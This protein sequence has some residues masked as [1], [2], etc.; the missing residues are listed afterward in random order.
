[1]TNSFTTVV[2]ALGE[3]G[4]RIKHQSPTKAVA[5]CPAHDDRAPSLS[6]THTDGRTL[7]KCFA[8]CDIAALLVALNLTAGQLFDDSDDFQRPD[9]MVGYLLALTN[10][11]PPASEQPKPPIAMPLYS[12]EEA[13]AIEA[14]VTSMPI[15]YIYT[16]TDGNPVG[17]KVR[18]TDPD[19][20]KTFRQYRWHDGQW[21]PG[22]NGIDLPLYNTQLIAQT[23]ADGGYLWIV[24]GEK[25]A[26]TLT[27]LGYPAVTMPN[28]AGSWNSN[29]TAQ[30][31]GIDSVYL[32]AD[33]DEP[34]LKHAANVI[35]QLD[36]ADI[37]HR[38]YLPAGNHKDI[39]DHLNAGLDIT[40]LIDA[41]QQ[42]ETHKAEQW[43]RRLDK[44]K[45]DELLRQT[46]YRDIK[47]QLADQQAAN[48][49][50]LPPYLPTLTEELA[51]ND[52]PVQWLITG[53]WPRHGNVS[54]T[55]PYK[56]GKTS[57]TNNVIKALIE[58]RDLFNNPSF[59]VD[60]PGRIAI[61]NYEVSP[62]QY[63]SW[64]R[65]MNLTNTDKVTVLNMRGF[66]WP[67]IH[68]YAIDHTIQWLADNHIR[69][70]VID[71]L[72][73][74]FTG[75][76]DENSNEDMGIFLDTLDVIKER[77]GVEN[78]MI[79][80]HAGRNA[81]AGITRARGASRF[82]D[83]VDV[84]WTLTTD[85]D[86]RYFEAFGRDVD[87]EQSHLAWDDT[88]RSQ[89]MRRGEGK[90]EKKLSHWSQ[91]IIDALKANGKPMKTSDL[92]EAIKGDLSS[93]DSTA[94]SVLRGLVHDNIV[95]CETI[96]RA[97]IYSLQ[98][99]QISAL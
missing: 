50:Q 9:S 67:L 16:D 97:N 40:D 64:L 11:R 90:K 73:R 46:A 27:K 87:I 61:W 91:Q 18:L 68:D 1:M 7:L 35:A 19:G 83:W 65:E 26:D 58:Q 94:L 98:N 12:R 77:A 51:Q 22:L 96:G 70:W 69:T 60:D 57:T 59:K 75:C 79:V 30:L 23:R 37:G 4:K 45:D 25:D 95:S 43:Q 63:R 10:I 93:R 21:L 47:R 28:G 36:A 39:T 71:P 56:S 74:A 76:G 86:D 72:A 49:Y 89:T 84:R 6:I 32:V 44:A 55:A 99:E 5:Q 81:E 33:N 41:N 31:A 66:T 15:E 14:T 13:T 2:D 52:E 24:E 29:H 80:A 78:L 20:K 88:D 42:I 48:R 3:L 8:G 38:L 34:G 17:K 54:L 53:L 92:A 85:G 82:D 62:Q